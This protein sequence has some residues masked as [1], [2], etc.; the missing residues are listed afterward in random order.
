MRVYVAGPMRGKPD[1]NRASFAMAAEKLRREGFTVFNPAAANLDNLP[2]HRIMS[3]V[4]SQLCECE[5]ITMLPGSW[6]SGGARIEYLLARYLGL[7]I[8]KL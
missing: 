6:R 2:L 8:I 4:L 5:A 1:L 7:K 3:H